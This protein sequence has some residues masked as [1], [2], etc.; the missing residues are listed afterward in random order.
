MTDTTTDSLTDSMTGMRAARLHKPG[1]P[2]VIEEIP[3]P[4]PGPFD[5]LIEV[6]AC[7]LC[8]TDIHLAVDGDIPVER[9]PITLG[10]E[11]AGTIKSTGDSV[12][13]HKT[14]ERVALFPSAICGRCRFCSS[15]RESLCENSKVYGMSRDGSLAQ[16]V[17]APEWS[18]VSIPDS[19]PSEVAAIVTDGVSTPFHALR[20][21]GAL[22]A[23]ESVA[24]VGCGGLG[25]HAIMLARM[26]G[27][28]SII[29]VDVQADARDRAL[30]LGADL[31][32]DPMAD[33]NIRKT[34]RGYLGRGVDLSLEFVGRVD[35]VETA[36]SLLD[37]G[38]RA[39]IVGVGMV[40]PSLPP[41]VSFIGREHSVIGSFGMDLKD[42]KDL[43][44]L[45]AGGRL[46]LTQ[47]ISAQYELG[48]INTA[49]SRLASKD[50]DVVRLVVNPRL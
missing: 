1:T 2:L 10:H 25:T 30:K 50:T 37:T 8:G 44:A 29:A 27:A 9:T 26:M 47:S 11:A 6:E 18:V 36:I 15:G 19:V 39:V 45:I 16:Y 20:S 33:P 3:I 41:L 24:I 14:G 49:L 23:G 31:A 13:N 46:D 42:I 40:R 21:R 32:I 28:R 4:S 22:K 43:F 12:T 48:E 38:G 34:I 5:L 7:G 17:V 35:T